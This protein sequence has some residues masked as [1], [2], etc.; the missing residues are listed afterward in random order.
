[1]K[2]KTVTYFQCLDTASQGRYKKKLSLLNLDQCPYETEKGKWEDNM[3]MW[4]DVMYPDIFTYLIDSPGVHTKDAMKAYKSLQSYNYFLSG[5]V[6]TVFSIRIGKDKVLFKANVNHSQRTTEPP[7]KVWCAVKTTG[8]ILSSHCD[9]MAGLGEVCSHVA[10]MLF[11][12]EA[13]V[14]LGYKESCTSVTCKWNATFTKKVNPVPVVEMD[15]SKPKRTD[16]NNNAT[17]TVKS[18]RA[19]K[20]TKPTLEEE[21]KFFSELA[22][23]F[24]SVVLTTHDVHHTK[25]LPAPLQNLHKKKSLPQLL[26]DVIYDEKYA[27]RSHQDLRSDAKEVFKKISVTSEEAAYL[28]TVTQTQSDCLTW[29]E[30]RAGR[31]SASKVHSVLHT[32][33]EKPGVSV[34]KSIC[35]AT[36]NSGRTSVPSLGWGLE[37]EADAIAVLEAVMSQLH[38]NFKISK[39][40]LYINPQFPYLA[41][42]PDRTVS[43]D[44]CGNGIVEVKCPYSL[45]DNKDILEVNDTYFVH[46][47]LKSSHSYFTQVQTQLNVC[48]VNYGYFVLWTPNG[49]LISLE[50]KSGVWF[51]EKEPDLR[52]FYVKHVMPSL[53]SG[54]VDQQRPALK[55]MTNNKPL[56]CVCDG[57]EDDREMVRCSNYRRCNKVWFH[58]ECISLVKAPKGYWLC[59]LCKK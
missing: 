3:K 34:L 46:N 55:T 35:N 50:K 23:N 36:F 39:C 21:E 20:V 58:L 8:D 33:Q 51:E 25:F 17:P 30:Q 10:A 53:M 49:S 31:I 28:E 59:P 12:T 26:K 45:R 54:R 27:D 13:C 2:G 18:R 40:G 43:C 38:V 22:K 19:A 29:H 4:P 48:D 57:E 1:M 56:Y 15:F 16:I 9:C 7:C 52:A 11:K 6:Q 24:K 37:H 41:A 47:T 14:R 32:N 5:Y 42:T 44:C